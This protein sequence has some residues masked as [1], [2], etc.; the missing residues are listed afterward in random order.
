M[1]ALNAMA[2]LVANEELLPVFM[3]ATGT[4]AAEL[5][6]S[7][8]SPEVL[9]GVLDFLT[10]DDAWVIACCDSAGLPYE[11]LQQARAALPGGQLPHWT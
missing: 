4:G 11:S 10:M 7:A 2:W 9:A 8:D 5:R 1:I 6:S 3:G